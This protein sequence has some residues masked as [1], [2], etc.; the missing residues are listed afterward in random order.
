MAL[1][2]KVHHARLDGQA[3][4]A[5]GRAIFDAT[6]EGRAVKPP[7]LRARHNQYQLG[8]AELLGAAISNT[9]IQV[10]KL[11]K[12]LPAIARA[13]KSL[14]LPAKD[15]NGKRDWLLPK[16][17][18]FLAP[19]TSFNVAITNQRRY[20]ATPLRRAHRAAGRGQ[21][22]RQTHGRIAQRRGDGHGGRRTARLLHRPP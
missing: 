7:R 22:D 15:A 18:N 19:R 2:T 21:G 13:G 10:V 6:A 8:V 20:A 3:G 14:L 16:D 17:L 5:L 9:A 1:Y 11:V 4:V 12:A